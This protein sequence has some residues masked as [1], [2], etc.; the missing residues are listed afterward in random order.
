MECDH[1]EALMRINVGDRRLRESGRLL[2]IG[3]CMRSR[4]PEIV[5]EF[6]ERD[7]GQAVLDVCMEEMHVNHAGFKIASIIR[8]SGIKRVTALTVDG[9][10]HCVQLH[11]V[12]EDIKRHFTSEVETAHYVVERGKVFEITPTAVKRSR[13]LSKIQH[14]L[15]SK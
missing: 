10:P 4:Y 3:S 2:L 12:I 9:S 6:R 8:Y 15:D 1:D 5:K 13:H 11:Y 7:G 14:M